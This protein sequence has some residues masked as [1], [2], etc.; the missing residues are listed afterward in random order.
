MGSEASVRIARSFL[1]KATPAAL[2]LAAALAFA[3]PSRADPP[4]AAIQLYVAGDFLA[5]ASAAEAQPS[6]SSKA[7]AARALMAACMTSD[8]SQTEGLLNRA[9]SAARQAMQLDPNSVE[10]RLE[11][12]LAFGVRARQASIAEAIAHNYAPR[13]HRLI[14]E[15]LAREPNNPWGHELLGAWHLEVLRR[16]GSAGAAAYGARLATGIAE[17]DRARALAPDDPMIAL[18][19]AVA[20]IELDPQHYAGQV[21]RLLDAATATSPHD[22]FETHVMAQARELA[23]VLEHDGPQAAANEAHQI[24]L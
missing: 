17:F 20:L 18:H 19:Y 10:G 9:E 4:G 2:C 15:A 6:S 22:A 8:R 13:G 16:G 7:F 23:A 21:R 14:L 3:A 24:F 5:A 1:R 11:M 12:A